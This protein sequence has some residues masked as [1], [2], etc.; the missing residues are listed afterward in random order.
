MPAKRMLEHKIQSGDGSLVL[1]MEQVP[2]VLKPL[3]L[4]WANRGFTVSFKVSPCVGNVE[5]LFVVD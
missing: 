5:W 2:K 4:S 1:Q 3:V